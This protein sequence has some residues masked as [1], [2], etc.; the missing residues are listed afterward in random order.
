MGKPPG[1]TEPFESP[2][3]DHDEEAARH[4]ANPK[5]TKAIYV[6]VVIVLVV[7]FLLVAIGLHI[8]S[9]E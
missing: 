1:F 2:N 8:P 5:A 9:G 4:G 3:L 7:L 6:A